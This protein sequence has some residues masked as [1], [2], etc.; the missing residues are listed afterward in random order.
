M[1]NRL[2]SPIMLNDMLK[3]ANKKGSQNA[4]ISQDGL[5]GFDVANSR[6][7]VKWPKNHILWQFIHPNGSQTENLDTY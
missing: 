2:G 5:L 6:P 4:V 3:S 7:T 1:G